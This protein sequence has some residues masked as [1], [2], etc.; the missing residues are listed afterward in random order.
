MSKTRAFESADPCGGINRK[1]FTRKNSM[2][3]LRVWTVL[4]YAACVLCLMGARNAGAVSDQFLSDCKTLTQHDHRL[5]GTPEYRQ[6]AEYVMRRLKE[7]GVDEV[8]QQQYNATQTSITNID[9]TLRL[10]NDSTVSR[11]IVPMRPNGIMPPNTAPEGITAPLT[12]VRGKGEQL[13]WP[14]SVLDKI[15]VIDFNEPLAWYEAFRMGARAVIFVADSLMQSNRVHSVPYEANLPR[16]FYGGSREDLPE[17]ATATLVSNITW[18]SAIGRNVAAVIRGT[19]PV[20]DLRRPE[21]MI[22]GANLD[23]YGE[24]PRLSPGARGAVNCAGLLN[25]AQALVRN[26]PKRDVMVVFFDGQAR[27]H[28]GSS[29]FY[30]VMDTLTAKFKNARV[31]NRLH[32]M[33]MEEEHSAK[34]LEVTRQRDPFDIDDDRIKKIYLRMLKTAADDE[35]YSALEQKRIAGEERLKTEKGS[36]EYRNYTARLEKVNAVWREWNDLRRALDKETVHDTLMDRLNKLRNQ[37]SQR[38]RIRVRELETQRQFVESDAQLESMRGDRWISCH[39]SLLVGDYGPRWGIVAGGDSRLFEDGDPNAYER[40]YTGLHRMYQEN[41]R[42]FAGFEPATVEGLISPRD[43]WAAPL[44]HC[45]EVA[46]RLG[47]Y[48][49]ATGTIQETL[50]FEGTPDDRLENLDLAVMEQQIRQIGRFIIASANSRHISVIRSVDPDRMYWYPTWKENST[51]DGPHIIANAP[52]SPYKNRYVGGMTV[53]LNVTSHTPLYRFI[54]VNKIPAFDNFQVLR[55]NANGYYAFGPVTMENKDPKQNQTAFGIKFDSLGTPEIFTDSKKEREP[56]Q[57]L[58][59]TPSGSMGGCVLPPLLLQP[60]VSLFDAEGNSAIEQEERF[61]KSGGGVAFWIFTR[62]TKRL[63]LFSSSEST[64]PAIV[65]LNNGEYLENLSSAPEE[66]YG[67]GF[68]ADMKWNIIPSTM[69]SGGDLWRLNEERLRVLRTGG[70]IKNSL[71]RLH[72]KAKELLLSGREAADAFLVDAFASAGFLAEGPI[73]SRVKNTM[74]DLVVS[75]MFLLIISLPFGFALERLVLNAKTVYGRIGGFVLFFIITFFI[76]YFTHPAFALSAMPLIIFLGFTIIVMSG[77]VISILAQKFE[78]ELKAM[79]GMSSSLH[80]ADVSRTG[81]VLAAMSMGISSMRRRPLRTALTAITTVLLTFT[82]LCFASFEFSP[83]IDRSFLGAPRG[84]SAAMFRKSYSDQ[85]DP[86]LIRV[87]DRRF[88]NK[89]H[90]CV[91]YWRPIAQEATKGSNPKRIMDRVPISNQSLDRHFSLEAMLGIDS[92]EL[93]YRRDMRDLLGVNEKEFENMAFITTSIAERLGVREGDI[94]H[95]DGMPLTLGRVLQTADMAS[96]TDLDDRAIYPEAVRTPAAYSIDDM[97]KAES[98]TGEGQKVELPLS[99]VVIVSAKN[100]RE[101]G[102][103]GRVA[104]F[105]ADSPDDAQDISAELAQMVPVSVYGTE[106]DGIYRYRLAQKASARGVGD[107]ILPIL[108]GGLVI[109]GTMLGSVTDREKEIYTFS[110]LGLAPAHVASLFFIEATVYAIIGGMGGYLVAQGFSA[111]LGL[112]S[113]YGIVAAPEINY[114]STNSI[115]TMMIVMGVVLLS[116]VYPAIKASKSANPGIMRAW[117]MPKPEGDR[118][119]ILFPFTV[120]SYDIT[121]VVSFLREHFERFSD[122]SLGVLMAKNPRI[123]MHD[124]QSLGIRAHIALAPFDLGVT[125]D[126]E[127]YSEP[128]EIQGIDEVRINIHRKSGLASDWERLNK[129]LFN[130]LRKQLLIWRSLPVETMEHYRSQTLNMMPELRER[131]EREEA[132]KAETQQS[133]LAAEDA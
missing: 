74:N 14:A 60:K 25:I 114:S 57:R 84:Y 99:S 53:R 98:N 72:N 34:L 83:G 70:I 118:F 52:G 92:R 13:Q 130:D 122:T 36:E 42:Q 127:L 3:R 44:V 106:S 71:E 91:R 5:S 65:A 103:T 4:S 33:E 94:V 132:Q 19:D 11:E 69:R 124:D 37:I 87:L 117:K 107:L 81:T 35:T 129:N 7:I 50:P 88:E 67:V 58:E 27:C 89:A 97:V 16:Y 17:G 48:N 66:P 62:K 68:A 96:I 126:F 115:I 54:D 101:A 59:A 2:N 51:M 93:R 104:L 108:L 24:A 40:L 113:H 30:R 86:S 45:G 95:V 79:Q 12:H 21:M 128:S 38:V 112:F 6:A 10:T 120:S 121:G 8:V 49:A 55:S 125:E 43:F 47:I 116:A 85:I 39:L 105:Y 90:T 111:V 76:L 100:A 28:A 23:T 80:S 63:K 56:F 77:M 131:L 9:L 18:K 78:A 64:I 102:A 73:Y 22:I 41:P 1:A 75:V 119:S 82:I 46:E 109:L 26:R 123:F 110:A 20:F 29:N 61:T 15:V 32:S 31:S 133:S